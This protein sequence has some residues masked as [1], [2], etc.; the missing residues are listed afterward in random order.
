MRHVLSSAALVSQNR[1]Q[2]QHKLK[3]RLGNFSELQGSYQQHVMTC[4]VRQESLLNKDH[5]SNNDKKKIIRHCFGL[6]N[7]KLKYTGC[8]YL[9]VLFSSVS[10]SSFWFVCPFWLYLCC[11]TT[12]IYTDSVKAEMFKCFP[13]HLYLDWPETDRGC[14]LGR[15]PLAATEEEVSLFIS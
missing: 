15:Y 12:C 4:S 11:K 13:W 8:F 6:L 1:C 14:P 9:H 2:R 5:I 3:E 10:C 7:L